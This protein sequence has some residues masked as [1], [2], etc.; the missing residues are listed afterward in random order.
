MLSMRLQHDLDVRDTEIIGNGEHL[1]GR[2]G[3]KERSARQSDS[4]GHF[5]LQSGEKGRSRSHGL[6]VTPRRR[7]YHPLAIVRTDRQVNA[8]R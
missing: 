6:V 3:R 4:Q 1:L 7:W 2:Q 5:W 8:T